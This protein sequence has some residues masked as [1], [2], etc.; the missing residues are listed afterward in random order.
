MPRTKAEPSTARQPAPGRTR[1]NDPEGMRR[2]VVE[3]AA[4]AFQSRGYASATMQEITQEVGATGGA[5]YHH[6]PTKKSLALAVINER[7]AEDVAATWLR[8]LAAAPSAAQGLAAVFKAIAAELD[9]RGAVQGCP[10]NN[11]ALEL[12]LADEDFRAGLDA[13]FGAWRTAIADKLRADKARGALP[14]GV[15]PEAFATLV[16]AT[17]SGA[18]A[19]AKAAQ[20]TAPLKTC[21]RQLRQ[22]LRTD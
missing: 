7:V 10:V 11:L 13:L 22:W 2:R 15:E 9:A 14:A 8:P 20:D 1:A 6:F 5:V 3:A 17:Y 18:M 19:M 4:Q 21:A 16:V 12:S